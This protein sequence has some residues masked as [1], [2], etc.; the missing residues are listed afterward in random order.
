MK[1][2][3]FEKNRDLSAPVFIQHEG[4]DDVVDISTINP[5]DPIVV[6]VATLDAQQGDTIT[7]LFDGKE[8]G[9]VDVD[10]PSYD[11]YDIEVAIDSVELGTYN[12]ACKRGDDTSPSIQA[13][14]TNSIQSSTTAYH[15]SGFWG[16]YL[17]GLVDAWIV[18]FQ[19]ELT[20]GRAPLIKVT[21]AA[22]KAVAF[23]VRQRKAGRDDESEIATLTYSG[24]AWDWKLNADTVAVAKG[25]L[26]SLHLSG[27]NSQYLAFV[28]AM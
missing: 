1:M 20:S 22:M 12:V 15:R 25:D 14:I 6:R 21:D 11:T 26:L 23:S 16:Q 8:V 7:L 13:T 17:C 24:T 2:T 3:N 9:S 27:S 28:M 10:D 19:C 4:D 5:G 18:P